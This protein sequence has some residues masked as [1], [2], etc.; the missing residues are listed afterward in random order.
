[1]PDIAEDIDIDVILREIAEFE[2]T[3]LVFFQDLKE[4]PGLETSATSLIEEIAQGLAF[5]RSKV[6]LSHGINSDYNQ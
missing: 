2:S 1:M 5:L 6:Y 3:A 4:R